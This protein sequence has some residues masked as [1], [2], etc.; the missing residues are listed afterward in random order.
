MLNLYLQDQYP[1][2]IYFLFSALFSALF[3]LS[4][5]YLSMGYIISYS[6]ISVVFF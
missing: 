2:I 4:L 1:G 6:L 3:L 5:G